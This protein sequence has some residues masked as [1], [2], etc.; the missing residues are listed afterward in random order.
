V[1]DTRS[2]L[3][4]RTGTIP[5]STHIEWLEHLGPDGSFMPLD[6][7]RERYEAAGI[8]RGVNGDVAR[9]CRSSV[10]DRRYTRGG[11][12]VRLEFI[13]G[14]ASVRPIG[15]AVVKP[16]GTG[17]AIELGPADGAPL[18]RLHLT[19]SEVAQL[20]AALKTVIKDREEAILLVE[21]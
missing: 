3:E 15:A 14:D 18:V 11:A 4:Y 12:T 16:D 10:P 17:L 13:D 7:L 2:V 1:I 21:D 19:A 6:S 9:I 8:H 20:G 5:T